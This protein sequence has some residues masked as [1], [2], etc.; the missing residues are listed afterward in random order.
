MKVGVMGAGAI[1]CYL[2]GR[3]AASGIPVVLVGRASLAAE[4]AQSGLR[5][6][7]YLGFDHTLSL[8]IDTD[9]AALDGC[10]VIL[11]TVKG[12]DTAAAAKLLDPHARIVSFQNG[13]NNPE[14]LRQI[15]PEARV[16]AGM[17]PFNV[18]RKPGAHFHQ[19]TSGTVAMERGDDELVNALRGAGLPTE[20]FDNMLGVMWGKLLVNLNNPVNALADMPIQQMIAQRDYRRVM[21][22]CVREGLS[23]VVAAGIRPRL[24][25]PL[26][27]R[28]IPWLLTLP[29]AIFSLI[30][31][32]MIHVD[33]QARS[34]MW[35]DLARGRATEIDALNGEIVRLAAKVGTPAPVNAAIV[36]LIKSAEGKGSPGIGAGDL[37]RRLGL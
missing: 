37:R 9:A 15:L 20:A 1:G 5:I 28:W 35:D 14:V 13:V 8:R 24:E 23:A 31:P 32:R 10:D 27:P 30:A 11:V 22:A 36:Q 19:G 26:P 25:V 12:G 34:S 33:P 3:L 29:D 6:T 21:A 7:D 4:V 16:L 17:V 18:L 2:G